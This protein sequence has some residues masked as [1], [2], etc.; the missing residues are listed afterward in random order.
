[1]KKLVTLIFLT[2]ISCNVKEPISVKEIISDEIVTIRPDYP[3]TVTKDSVPITIPLEFE[4]TS[5]TK[6]LRNLKLYFISINNERLLDDISDY[7]TYYKENKTERIFFSLNKDDLEVNQKNHIIIKLRT[8]MISRKD[9][10][11]ILKKYNIKRSFENLKFRDTIKLTGY[12]Q[13]R[14]D[15]PTL[16]EGFRKVND[17]IVFSILLKGGERIHVS[18]KISW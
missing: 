12:N 15:N 2:F 17:S 4:I 5:N 18:Q 9:A 16:I 13:F 3:K 14:K 10:E 8:Q 6:D 1:M 11:I 7:Q